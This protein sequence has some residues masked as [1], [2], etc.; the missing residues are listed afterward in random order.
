[1]RAVQEIMFHLA[2][3][4]QHLQQLSRDLGYSRDSIYRS[5]TN[6]EREGHLLKFRKGKEVVV[7]L[8]RSPEA[9]RQAE[10]CVESV[11][12]GVDPEAFD[13]DSVVT[14]WKHLAGRQDG[15]VK[16]CVDAT[17]LSYESVRKAFHFFLDSSLARIVTKKP[18]RVAL[19][20]GGLNRHL[21]RCFLDPPEQRVFALSATAFTKFYAPPSQVRELLLADEGSTMIRGVQRRVRA[22]G[23]LRIIEVMQE[24]VT[25][26]TVFLRE[27]RTADGV[28]DFCIQILNGRSL[29]FDDLLRLA[30]ERGE[31][32][33]VGCYLDLL[34]D[35]NSDLVAQA[36][37][38]RFLPFVARGDPNVFL[39]SEKEFGKDGWGEE[40]YERKWNVDLYLDLGAI[41]HGVRAVS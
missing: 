20:E 26:E 1:M 14:T 21:E 40:P 35:L 31:A 7:S 39:K 4:P 41:E 27:L 38:E 3:G 24:E 10:L 16:E 18:L 23:P 29:N 13:Q 34:S 9:R 2:R 17:G 33:I 12:H 5:V 22:E 28:E 19:Q 11:A 25:P 6:L 8:S 36:D 32:N 37:G 15:S 30:R